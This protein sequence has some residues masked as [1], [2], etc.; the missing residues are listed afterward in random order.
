MLYPREAAQYI[1][2]HSKDVHISLDGVKQTARKIYEMMVKSEVLV[3]VSR[4]DLHDL[5]PKTKDKAA[6]DWVFVVDLLNFS[7]WSDEA[8]NQP[9]YMVRYKGR[10]W[11]GYWSL[12]AAV[13]RAMDEGILMTDPNVYQNMSREQFEYIVRS[14]VP[15]ACMPLI[16]ERLD[17]LHSAGQTLCQK[18][19]GSFSNAVQSCNG[20]ALELLRLIVD[21]F[22]T[23]R[24]VAVYNGQPVALYKRAQILVADIW[25]CCGGQGLGKFDDIDNITAFADYR[26]PQALVWL[27]AMQYSES[28]MESL[29]NREM[30]ENGDR[31]EVE[32][33]G[34][35]L[36]AVELIVK[37][38]QDM[39]SATPDTVQHLATATGEM[40]PTKSC[41]I[42]AILIDHF[43]W[44]FRREHDAE[45]E[46]IP[47]HRTRCIYY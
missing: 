7:F 19:G 12:C 2:K 14:D 24:D 23:F 11:T 33:R 47:F 10:E 27:G 42:N 45:M 5:N 35:L 43:L 8:D 34:C 4:W 20:S 26:I 3:D 18:F 25:A 13:N 22:P 46:S 41:R 28:L 21:N 39:I 16:A 32:I 9:K 30:L 36:W 6:I 37:E 44:D 40:A 1:A 17:S 31:R 15:V 29:K 38:L